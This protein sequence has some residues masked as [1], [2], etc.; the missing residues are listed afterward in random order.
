MGVFRFDLLAKLGYFIDIAALKTILS[1]QF[2][3]E[4]LCKRTLSSLQKQN[5]ENCIVYSILKPRL[6]Y[7][8]YHARGRKLKIIKS[9]LLI[10]LY[11][12]ATIFTPQGDGNDK[13][14]KRREL[15]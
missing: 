11:F 9:F 7:D 6:R 1:F 14:V 2:V 12:F 8:I 10:E 4:F 13:I 3:F 5:L 15:I